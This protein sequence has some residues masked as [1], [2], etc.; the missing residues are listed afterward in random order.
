MLYIIMYEAMCCDFCFA[1]AKVLILPKAKKLL[2][3]NF[4]NAA[5]GFLNRKSILFTLLLFTLLLLKALF[6]FLLFTLLLLK[7][8]FTFLLFYFFTFIC[9]F[10]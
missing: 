6:T 3:L 4:T 2:C 1:I 8:L 5:K 7:A 9:T 10:A